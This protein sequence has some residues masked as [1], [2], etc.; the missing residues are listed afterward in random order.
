VK[1]HLFNLKFKLAF[2][3]YYDMDVKDAQKIDE[4]LL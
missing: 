2:L 1:I 4:K 3:G